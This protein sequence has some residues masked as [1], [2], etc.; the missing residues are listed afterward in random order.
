[1][2][3]R[4]ALRSKSR[5]R[6]GLSGA[7]GSGKTWSALSIANGLTGSWD[8]V[9]IID[10]ENGSADLYAE[11]GPYSVCT[12]TAPYEPKKYID[13]IKDAEN[14]GFGCII[15]DSLTHAWSGE[16][17]MLD[18]Q[19]KIAD[20]GKGNSYTA[21]RTVTPMHNRLVETILTSPC[22]IIVT[23]RSKTE[24]VLEEEIKNG[25]KIQVPKKVGMAPIYRDGLEYEMTVFFELAQDHTASVSKDRTGLFDGR[26]FVPDDSTGK[27]LLAWLEGGAALPVCVDCGAEVT[28]TAKM[29][30]NALAAFA[31]Q[32]FG[33]VLCAECMRKL[34]AKEKENATPPSPPADD[35]S[36]PA[37][38][39][40]PAQ[41]SDSI[42]S[43][44]QRKRLWTIANKREDILRQVLLKY[45]YDSTKKILVKDYD[46][47]CLEIEDA[48]ISIKQQEEET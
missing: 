13:A 23:A 43:E 4:K 45:R 37:D 16:G 24:Y 31:E 3:F 20:S 38:D 2:A 36:P 12:L 18:I 9:A 27:E 5:L 46:N 39:A 35:V 17:G 1:M 21:W 42:I 33:R 47:I 14:A 6:L 29:G 15:I 25:R 8:K 28:P 30:A 11:R 19:G 10:T 44:A 22:H 41:S 7:S 26:Y 32:R 48:L 34:R 40:P